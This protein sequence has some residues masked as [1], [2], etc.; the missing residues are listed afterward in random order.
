MTVVSYRDYAVD[1]HNR[2]RR[3]RDA[4]D[5]QGSIEIAV[6]HNAFCY[7]SIEMLGAAYTRDCAIGPLN[8]DA[9]LVPEDGT[10]T[11]REIER[12]FDLPEIYAYSDLALRG[13][14][15]P[16]SKAHWDGTVAL[17]EV[18]YDTT[19]ANWHQRML[20]IGFHDP[21]H[22][23]FAISLDR[24]IFADGSQSGRQLFEW[25]AT[26]FSREAGP[27]GL[28]PTPGRT[29][30]A[31]RFHAS[32]SGRAAPGAAALQLGALG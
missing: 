21:I 1:L 22:A 8:S 31:V 7:R 24:D 3:L 5:K 4:H 13:D 16:L 29:D 32:P 6:C 14:R 28:S 27:S 19:I 2:I 12:F 23:D 15:S 20:F 9:D 18:C 10:E 17:V 26:E 30:E 11:T 25:R